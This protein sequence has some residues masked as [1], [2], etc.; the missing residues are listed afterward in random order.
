M[1][2]YRYPIYSDILNKI[3]DWDTYFA[4]YNRRYMYTS[5]N[6]QLEKDRQHN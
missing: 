5:I 2:S 4:N 1:G 3:N 6:T